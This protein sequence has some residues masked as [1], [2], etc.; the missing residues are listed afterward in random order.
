M[1]DF[2][3]KIETKYAPA[4]VGPYSQAVIAGVGESECLFVSGQL[5]ID[6][7]TGKLVEGDI[8]SSARLVFEHMKAIIKAAGITMDSVVRVDIFLKD[9]NDFSMVNEVYQEYF[10]GPIYPARQTVQ[11]AKL[12]LDAPIEASC[13]A[14]QRQPLL[15]M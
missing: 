11:V 13:I 5:P 12:P 14:V 1:V 10:Q 9:L 2:I 6:L 15:N 8:R 3:D 4:A 7:S